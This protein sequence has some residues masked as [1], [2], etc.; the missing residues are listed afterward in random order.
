MPESTQKRAYKRERPNVKTKSK[1]CVTVSPRG[2]T[3]ITGI[4]LNRTYE[5]LRSGVM[6]AIQVANRF[7]IPKAALLKWLTSAGGKVD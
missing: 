4:G 1:Q 5:L 7:Y 2:S 6:P 3:A